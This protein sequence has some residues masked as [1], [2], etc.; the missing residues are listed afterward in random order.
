MDDR[1]WTMEESELALVHRPSA[2]VCCPSF[3][4]HLFLPS[5]AYRSKPLVHRPSSIV[6]RPFTFHDRR[7]SS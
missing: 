5:M 7:E 4:I 3:I 2:M 6:Y 1:R